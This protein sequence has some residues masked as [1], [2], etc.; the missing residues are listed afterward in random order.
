MSVVAALTLVLLT[1]A[2]AATDASEDCD[3]YHE[4]EGRKRDFAKALA[5]YRAQEDWLMVAIMQLNG[6]GTPVDFAAARES[7][8]KARHDNPTSAD[9][10][11][12]NEILTKREAAP[13]AKGP[14]V[15]FCRDVA[16]TTPSL[17]VCRSRALARA[18]AKDDAA[19]TKV[20][21]GLAPSARATFDQ[22]VSAFRAFVIAEGDRAY[23][24]SIDGTIRNQAAMGQESLVRRSFMV[25]I[26]SVGG[27]APP[28]SPRSLADADGELNAV[29]RE[30]VRSYV[31]TWEQLAS[32]ASEPST[33]ATYEGYA[34]DLREK[35][36][37]AQRA[38]IRYRDAA[39]ELAAVRWP[40]V[41]VVK[42]VAKARIT[43]D[44]IRELDSPGGR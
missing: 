27:A 44:R 17:D 29:Y 39:A 41:A 38:W 35:S 43:E 34:A 18:T 9:E 30:R 1:A 7:L 40:N 20:R 13:A 15:D 4:G 10:D 33:A 12:L 23:Q 37:G 11:A 25:F 36:R 32:E 31:T 8:A 19:I 5:C 22:T 28:S 42:D 21:E 24:E 16:G 26:R 6:E 2:P 3:A 14:R